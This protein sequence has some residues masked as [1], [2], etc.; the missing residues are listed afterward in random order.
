MKKNI[1]L[2]DLD[3]TLIKSIYESKKVNIEF[4]ITEADD[5]QLAKIKNLYD[6][7]NLDYKIENEFI[8]V[9]NFLTKHDFKNNTFYTKNVLTDNINK[10]VGDRRY[11]EKKKIFQMKF[12]R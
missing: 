7:K 1:I 12:T 6:I 10:I 8:Q 9:K 11:D 5:T 3:L 4:L 2:I